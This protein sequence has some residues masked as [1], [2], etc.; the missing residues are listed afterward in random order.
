MRLEAA[1]G[2]KMMSNHQNEVETLRA[3][4]IEWKQGIQS[5]AVFWDRWMQERGGQW[6]EDF[7]NRFDP[8]A[9]LDPWVAG[10]ARSLGKAEVSILDVGSGPVPA[11]GYKLDG[12]AL[13]ITAVDPLASIYKNLLT[14]HGLKPPVMSMFALVEELGSFFEPNSFDITHCRN[15][16]DH[17]FDPLRG[18][19]EILKVVDVGGQVLLRHHP[20]EAEHENYKGFHHYNFDCRDGRFV[21]WNKSMTVDVADFLTGHAEVECAMPAYVEVVIRKIRDKSGSPYARS[22]R[23]RQYLQA[24]FE[25]FYPEPR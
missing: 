16:L 17:S 21:I 20:N 2:S 3:Q 22:D 24:L 19:S 4:L 10:V 15:A 7:R 23:I 5:E 12:V 25:I 18:I 1:R 6:P 9:A 8:N 14:R 11:I 13:H